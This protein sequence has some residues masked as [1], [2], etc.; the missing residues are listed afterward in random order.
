MRRYGCKER[1]VI[2][3]SSV[4]KDLEVHVDKKLTFSRHFKAQANE[5]N[6]LLGLISGSYEFLDAEK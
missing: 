1:V 5:S 6:K 2:E 3:K 4:E